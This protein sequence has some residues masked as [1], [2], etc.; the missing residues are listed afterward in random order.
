[1]AKT[2]PPDADRPD[3]VSEAPIPVPSVAERATA[4]G[5]L[6][7]GRRRDWSIP[8]PDLGRFAPSLSLVGPLLMMSSTV[9]GWWAFAGATGE[10]GE[11]GNVAFG[12]F[13]GA[14]SI[15]LMAW[16]FLLAV[17]FRFLEPFFGG[18][19]RAYQAHRWAGSLSVVMMFLHTSIEPEI[20]GGIRGASRSLAEQAEELAGVGEW[21]IYLL[22]G[23]S[24]LRWFP[25]RFWRL[26][27]KLLGIPF[28]FASWHFFTAEKTYANNSPWGWYFG[29]IMGIGIAAYLWRVVVR[30]MLFRGRSYRV[31]SADVDGTTLDLELAPNGR[32]LHH[33]AGQ[34]AVL[35]FQ[36][37]GLSEPH[38]FTI[39]SS[40]SSD[41]LR[42]FIRDL[43]DW[44][45]RLRHEDIEGATVIVEGPY[46]HFE[47][48]PHGGGHDRPVVWVAGG[49]GITPFLSV[50]DELE[51]AAPGQRPLLIYC[52]RSEDDATAIAL[53]RAAVADGRIELA[54]FAS[55]EGRRFDAGTD[56]VE[57]S[58]GAMVGAHVAVCGPSGLV[59]DV[60][61]TARRL[62]ARNVATEAF[63]IRS[64]VGPDLSKPIDELVR[65]TR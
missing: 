11:G 20:E 40:P 31:V 58:G 34:F 62:G 17:R 3:A 12:L 38:P 53:L 52:V 51:P 44:S 57:S 4:L 55:A 25:Y 15:V 30:D 18:L 59:G 47:P 9:V 37:R 19:D 60:T 63:D 8:L 39:A 1:M 24:L 29:S 45:G 54:M 35:K 13:V 16:S 10:P 28:L 61:R 33:R 22:V 27:H 42:F 46:G 43:G 21:M 5:R 56:L 32:K 2:L 7:I 65:S 64:G 48:L 41:N 49:V 26:T 14:A 50:I 23:I 36:K 6:A